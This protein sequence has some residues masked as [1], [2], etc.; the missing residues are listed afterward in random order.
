MKGLTFVQQIALILTVCFVLLALS[1]YAV[2]HGMEE[3]NLEMLYTQ[4]MELV[5][6]S[7]REAEEELLSAQNAAYDMI[8]SNAVQTAVSD[9]LDAVDAGMGIS[10]LQPFW[11]KIESALVQSLGNNEL[12]CCTNFIDMRGN[13]RAMA[14]RSYHKLTVEQAAAVA[15]RAVAAEGETLLLP[16]ETYSGHKDELLIVKQLREKRNLSMRHVGVLVLFVDMRLL[17]QRLTSTHNGI[18]LLES[19]DGSLRYVLGE[20]QP[21]SVMADS[22]FEKQAEGALGQYAVVRSAGDTFFVVNTRGSLFDY[23]ISMKYGPLFEQASSLEQRHTLI[24]IGC[25]LIALL[26][27]GAL[28]TWFSADYQK[29]VT[30]I[31][32]VSGTDA[33]MIPPVSHIRGMNR[34]I[35]ELAVAFN[36]MADRVNQLIHDNYQAQLLVKESQLLAMQAQINPHFLYNTL[37]SIYWASQSS[38]NAQAAAMAESLSQLLR[39]AVNINE[40]VVT[41]DRELEI[42][43]NYIRIQKLRYAERLNISF[44]VSES[45]SGCAVPKF[46]IQP[47]MENAVKYGAD[48]MLERCDI[49]IRIFRKGGDCICLVTNTGPGPEDGGKTASSGETHTSVGLANIDQRIKAIFGERYGVT[50]RRDEAAGKTIAQVIMKAMTPEQLSRKEGEG[51]G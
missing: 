49:E 7:V 26:F 5:A 22:S 1:G 50:L 47:L 3:A 18:Y 15:E 20:E 9:Y 31:R 14:S 25:L 11:D 30:H 46:T 36:D 45:C 4:T 16:G 17:G 24:F 34:E 27:S 38:G 33:Q 21:S 44:D 37:N 48:R 12:I 32:S 35:R 10:A 41:M 29:L 13:V 51:I 28:V 6:L 39:E 42:T 19:R 23:T 8:V 40:S 43:C 2:M